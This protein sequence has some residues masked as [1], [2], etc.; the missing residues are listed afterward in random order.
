VASGVLVVVAVV[1]VVAD[2]RLVSAG[3]GCAVVAVVGGGVALGWAA[4]AGVAAGFGATGR[5]VAGAVRTA[6]AVD[7]MDAVAGRTAAGAPEGTAEAK[8]SPT[9]LASACHFWSPVWRPPVT[10]D[11][12]TATAT[13]VPSNRLPQAL[14]PSL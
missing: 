4:G 10:R 8:A 12:R 1:A 9:L 5:F 13:W 2:G 6:G 14:T 3:V 7:D 11:C